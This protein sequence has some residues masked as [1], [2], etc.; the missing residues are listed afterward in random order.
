EDTT[1]S[2]ITTTSYGSGTVNCGIAF[3]APPSGK[4]VFT[5]AGDLRMATTAQAIYL[6]FQLRTGNTVGSGTI[7]EDAN[8]NSALRFRIGSATGDAAAGDGHHT[9]SFSK[10][11]T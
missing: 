1:Q 10:L 9:G 6:A 4:V 11:V 7:V 2:N 5:V 8:D 3:I